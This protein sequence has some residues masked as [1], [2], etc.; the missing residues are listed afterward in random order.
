MNHTLDDFMENYSK[1]EKEFDF[2]TI[3]DMYASIGYKSVTINQILKYIII[4]DNRQKLQ[5]ASPVEI[6]NSKMVYNVSFPKCCSAIPGDEIVGV[7]SKN[8]IAIHTKNCT[9]LA[10][11]GKIIVLNAKWK[12]KT[13]REFSVNVKIIAKDK[14]GFAGKLFELFSS[15][16]INVSKIEA[17]KQGKDECEFKL[18]MSVRDSNEL[19]ELISKVK[20]LD[21]VIIISRAFE[22]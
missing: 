15:E 12:E 4:E 22:K 11:M 3:D 1:I 9:N 6:E 19:E 14:V 18:S 17:K 2:P 5:K 10:K 20:K 8:G 21:E 16:N 7:I 13:N